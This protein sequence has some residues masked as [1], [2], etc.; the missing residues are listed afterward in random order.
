MRLNKTNIMSAAPLHKDPS[1]ENKTIKLDGFQWELNTF[2]QSYHCYKPAN[3]QVLNKNNKINFN[4]F[5]HSYLNRNNYGLLRTKF[6]L[7]F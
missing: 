2:E 5:G 4:T 3:K 6:P 7:Y 1:Y